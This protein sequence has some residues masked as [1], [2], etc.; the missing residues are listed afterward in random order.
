MSERNAKYV[1]G[2]YIYLHTVEREYLKKG[3]KKR[4]W[5][6]IEKGDAIDERNKKLISL[7]QTVSGQREGYLENE[8][9]REEK[10]RLDHRAR[11]D[12]SN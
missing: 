11:W 5:A 6:M 4:E 7:G 2:R 8:V 10:N 9:R 1:R 12:G 3:E